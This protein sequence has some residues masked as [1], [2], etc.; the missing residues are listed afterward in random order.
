MARHSRDCASNLQHLG[1]MVGADIDAV[2]QRDVAGVLANKLGL[3][4]FFFGIGKTEVGK[5]V[6]AAGSRLLSLPI[7]CLLLAQFSS[8][9]IARTP[10]GVPLTPA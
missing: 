9:A 10:P 4:K 6:A 1:Q 2:N 7:A 5:D 8:I 3:E